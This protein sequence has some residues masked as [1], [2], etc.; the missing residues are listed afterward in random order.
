M[1]LS[2]LLAACA[3]H[4]S[5]MAAALE[6]ADQAVANG[7]RRD[8]NA[9]G[10]QATVALRYAYLVERNNNKDG[11]LQD[12]IRLLKEAINHARFGRSDAGVQAAEEA[13]RLLAE[14]Q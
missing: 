3:Q 10:E 12:V 9:L 4:D 1:V 8:N 14:M 5:Y 6:H 7:Q 2:I 11:R 13:Y